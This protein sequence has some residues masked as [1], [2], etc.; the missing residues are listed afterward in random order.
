MGLSRGLELPD[1]TGQRQGTL[2]GQLL[3][4]LVDMTFLIRRAI[5]IRKTE[6]CALEWDI[7]PSQDLLQDPK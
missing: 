5:E 2:I 6:I 3:R 1:T 7:V 4:Q